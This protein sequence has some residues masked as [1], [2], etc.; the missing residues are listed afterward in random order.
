MIHLE[1]Q[2]DLEAQLV[3]SAQSHGLSVEQYA[4]SI[5]ASAVEEDE[6]IAEGLADIAAGRTRLAREF[7]DEFQREHDIRG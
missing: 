4:E 6:A 7:F 1:L 2:P 5:L 3:T